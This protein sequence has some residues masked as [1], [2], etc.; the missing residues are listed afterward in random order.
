MLTLVFAHFVSKNQRFI[1]L[2]P[3]PQERH[4]QS[5]RQAADRQGK[6]AFTTARSAARSSPDV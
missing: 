4:D 1:F 5:C 6:A 2:S 3:Q